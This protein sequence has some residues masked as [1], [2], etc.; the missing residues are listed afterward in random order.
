MIWGILGSCLEASKYFHV[1]S[2]VVLDYLILFPLLAF[3]LPLTLSNLQFLCFPLSISLEQGSHRDIGK[4]EI[5][6]KRR[7]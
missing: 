7:I 5:T 2:L 1:L 4:K 3:F 6:E